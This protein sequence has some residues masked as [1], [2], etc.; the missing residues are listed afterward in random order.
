MVLNQK[1]IHNT[2]Q[3]GACRPVDY[4]PVYAVPVQLLFRTGVMNQLHLHG[5]H[6]NAVPDCLTVYIVP[7]QELLRFLAGTERV[8]IEARSVMETV[9]DA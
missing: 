3:T 8:P 5:F 7:V 4:D 1:A 6:A 2:L 9:R